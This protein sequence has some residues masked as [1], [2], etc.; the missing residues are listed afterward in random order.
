M[1]Q[2]PYKTEKLREAFR[3]Q[4]RSRVTIRDI[5]EH[6]GC[7]TGYVKSI[8][9]G[10]KFCEA[11]VFKVADFLGVPRQELVKNGKKAKTS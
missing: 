1:T 7:S 11:T 2:N 10:R 8:L 4:N 3:E 5:A 9:S 6:L